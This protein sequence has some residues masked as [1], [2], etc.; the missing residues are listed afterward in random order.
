MTKILLLLEIITVLIS[1]LD[2]SVSLLHF[3]TKNMFLRIH[4]KVCAINMNAW[5]ITQLLLLLDK[6]IRESYVLKI[7]KKS[8]LTDFLDLFNALKK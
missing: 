6:P 1:E 7:S 5:E 3:W 2:L 8:P 4:L